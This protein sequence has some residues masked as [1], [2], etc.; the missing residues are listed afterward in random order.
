MTADELSHRALQDLLA[1]AACGT[2]QETLLRAALIV[3]HGAAV[4]VLEHSQFAWEDAIWGKPHDL[5]GSLITIYDDPQAQRLLALFRSLWQ[6]D[7]FSSVPG[8]GLSMPSPSAWPETD[9]YHPDHKPQ[10]LLNCEETRSSADTSLINIVLGQLISCAHDWLSHHPLPDGL[11]QPP[12]HSVTR[13]AEFA[14]LFLDAVARAHSGEV[15]ILPDLMTGPVRHESPAALAS[16]TRQRLQ[17]SLSDALE[18]A[19]LSQRDKQ[20]L[21]ERLLLMPL[22]LAAMYEYGRLA[23]EPQA[24][25]MASELANQYLHEFFGVPPHRIHF[26]S[27]E[28][29]PIG[30][31]VAC[32]SLDWWE[33]QDGQ[34]VPSSVDLAEGEGDGSDQTDKPL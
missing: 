29:R 9:V 33:L 34:F 26:A 13:S 22:F 25:E 1:G 15:L 21:S 11:S 12:L 17:R 31:G 4:S 18:F 7:E 32:P 10:C 2:T 28:L 6:Q 20:A 8:T 23:A 27:F 30:I 19:V 14:Q 16:E 3:S 5:A 24:Q